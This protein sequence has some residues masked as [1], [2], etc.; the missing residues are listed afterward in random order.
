MLES[1]LFSSNSD[2]K[3]HEDCDSDLQLCR[4]SHV[5]CC[6]EQQKPDLPSEAARLY[7]MGQAAHWHTPSARL[8]RSPI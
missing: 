7:I 5:Q 8:L 6:Q 4:V 3:V 2:Y 1:F